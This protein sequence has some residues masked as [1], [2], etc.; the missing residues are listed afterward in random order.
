MGYD[1]LSEIAIMASDHATS[2]MSETG[3]SYTASI[4]A[5]ASDELV[6]THLIRPAAGVL[7]QHLYR[8]R[9]TP[10]HVT[11]VSIIV[12]LFAA[13][14]FAAGSRLEVALAGVAV[15][16][17]DILDSADGQL[18]R[19]QNSGSRAGRFLDSI[20][21][22]IV[23]AAIF[24]GISFGLLHTS[25]VQAPVLL[26]IVGFFGLTLRVSYH[27]FY[28]TSYLHRQGTYSIN[29][30]T[31]EIRPEDRRADRFTLWLQR[32]FH[33][34]YGWQDNL[35]VMLDRWSQQRIPRTEL[36]LALWYGDQIALRLSSFLGLGTELAVLTIFA[37]FNALEA[38]LYVN[39]FFLNVVWAL[40]VLYRRVVLSHRIRR[41][42]A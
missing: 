6:N 30:V 14:L 4:K 13:L 38:Y 3:Y 8:T 7:V 12:G 24:A 10:N 27:V 34:L 42:A 9:V 31:E 17:K 22:I 23:D 39:I 25:S 37:L 40:C 35:M 5:D 33:V 15:T 21:D 32:I 41:T 2:L 16:L 29:R 36:H 20:G 26:A 1:L 11:I 18:A 28:Q 19:A